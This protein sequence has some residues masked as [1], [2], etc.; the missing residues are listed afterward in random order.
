MQ[1]AI[2][3]L[4]QALALCRKQLYPFNKLLQLAGSNCRT[5]TSSCGFQVGF[6]DKQLT[7][8]ILNHKIIIK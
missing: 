3:A 6:E 1:E 7:G 8:W 4:Q 2:V 5:S